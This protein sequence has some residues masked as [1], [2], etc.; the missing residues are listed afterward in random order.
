M[1]LWDGKVM[2]SKAGERIV[3]RTVVLLLSWG[4]IEEYIFPQTVLGVQWIVHRSGKGSPLLRIS[5]V[6]LGWNINVPKGNRFQHARICTQGSLFVKTGKYNQ[7]SIPDSINLIQLPGIELRGV[8]R[9]RPGGTSNVLKLP[10]DLN[11]RD[12]FAPSF[13]ATVYNFHV[14]EN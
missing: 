11:L 13:H 14:P 12:N 2:K 1:N 3:I 4:F 6:T 5:W 8:Y 10:L 7:W 9:T